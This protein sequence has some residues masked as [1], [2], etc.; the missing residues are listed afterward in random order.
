MPELP[1]VECLTRSV[2]HVL[3]GQILDEA[4]FY[5]RDLRG[6]IPV[7]EFQKDLVGKRVKKVF[8][9]SKY[10]LIETEEAFGIIH[11]GMSGQLI[12]QNGPQP[13]FKHTHAVFR[14]RR[15]DQGEPLYLHYIDPRRFGW[16]SCCKRAELAHHPF[17]RDLG[18]E[19][20]LHEDLVS[21][22]WQKSRNKSVSIKSFLMDAK[23]LV[24]VGN[25]YANEA[26]FR[27]GIR[28]GRPASRV[29][30]REF[31]LLVPAIRATLNE[32]IEAGGTTFR[33]HRQAD[34]QPGYFAVSLKVYGRGGE[35]CLQCASTIQQ[36]RITGR[37]TYYCRRCQS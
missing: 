13:S 2:R 12:L 29:R 15:D 27:A 33:D 11:L 22:L 37:A 10:M 20:L 4:T 25:I 32:A 28:P 26:L 6:E 1:E 18:P 36:S 14:V 24:G 17:F 5:R 21:Y 19:P 16:I 34:G 30:R 7:E 35:A 8:R 23:I 31:E 9:R 3:E